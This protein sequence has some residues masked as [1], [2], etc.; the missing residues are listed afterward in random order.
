MPK[1]FLILTGFF[2]RYYCPTSILWILKFIVFPK[3]KQGFLKIVIRSWDWFLVRFFCQHAFISQSKSIKIFQK[4][5]S[6]FIVFFNWFSCASL[7]VKVPLNTTTSEGYEIVRPGALY[8]VGCSCLVS[9]LSWLRLEILPKK[10]P[11]TI[12][13]WA[14]LEPCWAMFLECSV[15]FVGFDIRFIRFFM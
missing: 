1:C 5:M 10:V 8:V 14:N 11:A 3:E 12:R 9:S 15:V 4:S 13:N 6:S 7:F 2:H